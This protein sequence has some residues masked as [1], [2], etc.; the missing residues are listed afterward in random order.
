MTALAFATDR[1]MAQAVLAIVVVGIRPREGWEND[2]DG[3]LHG[4]ALSLAKA[5]TGVFR[6]PLVVLGGTG[7]M[8]IHALLCCLET[9]LVD[10][11]IVSD[12]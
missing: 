3:S 5:S 2:T 9:L 11:C 4:D 8:E 1:R 7:M 6:A 10:V 12:R